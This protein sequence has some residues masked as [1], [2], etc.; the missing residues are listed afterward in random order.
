[1]RKFLCAALA[2]MLAFSAVGI[3]S[4][5]NERVLT[6]SEVT[7]KNM[8]MAVTGENTVRGLE[9]KAYFGFDNVDLTGINSVEINAYNKISGQSNGETLAVVIDDPNSGKLIGTVT[10]TEVGEDITAKGSIEPTTGVHKLYFRCLYAANSW[11]E[12]QIKKITLSPKK[13][14]SDK[15]SKKVPDSKVIDVYSDTWVAVDDMGR[16]VADYEEV[17]DVKTDTR[18]VGLLY[19]DWFHST[20]AS[21][22]ANIISEI[23]N[24]HPEEKENYNSPVWDTRGEYYWAEPLLGFYNSYDYWVYR[25]HAEMISNAGVDSIY[26]DYSNG[27][28]DFI[29]CLNI[30]AQAFRD[31]KASGVDIPRI[32]AMMTLGGKPSDAFRGLTAIYYNCFVENDYSDIWYYYEGKPLLYANAT[33]DN[34]MKDVE[35]NCTVEKGILDGIKDFFTYRMQGRRNNY[36][37]SATGTNSWMWLENFPQVLRNKDASGRPEF[38]VVGVGINQSTIYGL[39]QTGVFSD[40]YNKG[41][42]YSEAFG[43]DYRDI[44]KRKAYFFREQAAL[45]LDAAPKFLMID[46]WN[47][48]T[49]IRNN[50][51]NGFKNSF[52]DLYDDENSRDFEPS[53]GVLKD[54]Y[55][56]LLCDLVRKFKGVR[57]APTASGMKTIDVNA[58]ASAWDSVGPEFLNNFQD[59][60]RDSEGLAKSREIVGGDKLEAW[61]YTTKV[62]NAVKS[63][64]VTFDNDNI[65]FMAKTEKD[66]KK[67]TENW[68][69]LFINID[70]NKAT[71]WEGYDFSVNVGGEGVISSYNGGWN[72]VG[73]AAYSVSGNTLQLA[74]PRSLLGEI[75]TVDL[76]FKWTDSVATDDILNFYKDG[77]SAPLGRFNYLFTEIAQTALTESE[78]AALKGTTVIKAGNNRM[79]VSGGKM[80]VYEADTRITPFEANGT[81][82]I[83]EETFNE[84]MGFGHTKTRYEAAF[85]MLLTY[86]YDM[87]DDLTEIDNY[88]WTYGLLDSNEVRV[89]G[90]VTYLSAAPTAKDGI[91]YIPVSMIA[92]CYGWTVKALGNGAYQISSDGVSDAMVNAALGHIG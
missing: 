17:G 1:M 34:A 22:R 70:R 64:K 62:N 69:N 6:A 7:D 66:I 43:E 29:P 63:A 28:I 81:L 89:N 77:S 80:N 20:A 47:E 55:Y 90:K 54:D 74:I 57:P 39:S 91:I 13:Y 40:Q 41:R 19:W 42:G 36:S 21:K 68:M 65:Y 26:F 92:E 16:A 61:H 2:V 85:N 8:Q 14:V 44:G 59:Y 75:S 9:R 87:N 4:A 86:H 35:A 51:Y 76:E 71:G 45:A 27:G 53:K 88:M 56:N 84:V 25:K 49:A 12:I 23:V 32:S 3:C 58:D 78:R 5:A 11:N 67:G 24:A 37:E 79:V 33:Y 15:E 60:E 10:L 48:W 83:P 46:G 82:Y 18:E 30:L 31:A 73:D 38:V 52:V 50:D 72:K